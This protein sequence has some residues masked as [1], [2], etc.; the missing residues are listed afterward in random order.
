LVQGVQALVLFAEPGEHLVGLAK[1]VAVALVAVGVQS[2]A[3]GGLVQ[4]ALQLPA[5]VLLQG[6][7][8]LGIGD[9]VKESGGPFLDASKGGVQVGQDAGGDE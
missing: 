5:G 7:P 2:A 4:A 6:A 8:V 3:G 9:A 1:Q